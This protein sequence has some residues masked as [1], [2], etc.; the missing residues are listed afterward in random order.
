MA[1]HGEAGPEIYKQPAFTTFLGIF[2]D[3]W[4][5]GK[6]PVECAASLLVSECSKCMHEDIR[7]RWRVPCC[8]VDML[9][10]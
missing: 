6:K 5:E 9:S 1:G 10:L 2:V 7:P 4:V 8:L 3:K